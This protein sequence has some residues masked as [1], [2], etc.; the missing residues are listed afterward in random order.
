MRL[1][2]LDILPTGT[3]VTIGS[4]RGKVLSV[5]IVPA[6]PSG[7]IAVHTVELTEKYRRVMGKEGK[8]FPLLKPEKWEGNY[9]GISV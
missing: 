6:H 4:K 2:P 5:K 9:S 3:P 8:W 1:K 7:M